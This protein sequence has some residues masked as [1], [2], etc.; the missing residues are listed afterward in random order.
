[1]ED[2]Q[3]F[4][5]KMSESTG[6]QH[7]NKAGPSTDFGIMQS[8]QSG[9]PG[10]QRLKGGISICRFGQIFSGSITKKRNFIPL[11]DVFVRIG[12]KT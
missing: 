9:L 4:K 12:N 3:F 1:M 8:P 2:Y 5:G 7:Q 6:D 11:L 10:T